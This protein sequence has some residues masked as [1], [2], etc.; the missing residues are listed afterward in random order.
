MAESFSQALNHN[1]RVGLI[2]GIKFGN[3]AKNI[4]HSQFVD[5]TLL[6]GGASTTIA[7]RFKSLLDKFMEY[8]RGLINQQKSCIYGWNASNQVIHN[9]A[10][11]F[12]VSC[13]LDWTH[14]SYLGMPVSLGPLKAGTKDSIIDKMK[15]NVQQWGSM[16]L[17]PKGRLILLKSGISSLALYRFSLFQARASFLHKKDVVLRHFLWKGGKTTRRNST[18][19]VGNKSFRN[20]TEGVSVL[21]H[22]LS[23][24]LPSEG[25]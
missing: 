14:F 4:N 18:L 13:N 3:G 8:S 9:I 2:F 10:N 1:R 22:P 25:R 11:I 5:D 12:G 19:S 6:I 15:R 17:N 23:L 7:R 21:G 16:W 24:I 20:K